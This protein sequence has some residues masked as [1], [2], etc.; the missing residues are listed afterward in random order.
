MLDS[1]TI[2]ITLAAVAVKALLLVAIGVV[3]GMALR[4]SSAACRHILWT[5]VLGG[6]LIIALSIPLPPLWALPRSVSI[7]SSSILA[8]AAAA[9]VS[10]GER[11]DSGTTGIPNASGSY[12]AEAEPRSEQMADVLVLLWIGGV[13]FFLFR[14]VAGQLA[15]LR[16]GMRTQVIKTGSA[17]AFL[18]KLGGQMHVARSVRLIETDAI[19][20]PATWGVFRPVVAIPMGAAAWPEARIEAAL[21]HELAHVR[22]HD[23]LTQVVADFTCTLLWFH[24]GVWYAAKKM[25]AE[26]E[27]AC[28]DEVISLGM[29]EIGYAESLLTLAGGASR[30]ASGYIRTAIGMAGVQDLESR[31]RAILDSATP[32]TTPSR[33][34]ASVGA[35]ALVATVTLAGMGIQGAA[36]LD[37]AVSLG[38]QAAASLSPDSVEIQFGERVPFTA[39]QERSALTRRFTPR[40]EREQQALACLLDAAQHEKQHPMDLVRERAVWALSIAEA[41]QVV[42]PLVAELA[43][44]DWRIRA[45]AAWA[46]CHIGAPEAREALT[47]R[48]RDPIWRVRSE[49][50]S[51]LAVLADRRTLDDMLPLL[52]DPA[53]QV[54]SAVVEYLGRMEATAARTALEERLSDPHVAVR[55]AAQAALSTL[56]IR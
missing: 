44:V 31:L 25:R 32:R 38:S 16:I 23:V 12:A 4:R 3:A 9:R 33:L 24:P 27:R 2:V 14:I 5:A 36:P 40:D 1:T 39:E 42:A 52:R 20:L 19:S 26:R 48:L 37:A 53:W 43:N 35:F 17:R 49:A 29:S 6:V 41:D 28:D 11:I 10:R 8:P 56:P 34:G 18:D 51:A 15:L 13:A 50:A 47:A 46:L 21:L 7:A 55:M 54:R 45:Y 22:R 30:G